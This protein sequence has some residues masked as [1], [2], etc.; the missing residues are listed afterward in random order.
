MT[1]GPPYGS[2]VPSWAT[3]EP[4]YTTFGPPYG[5]NVPS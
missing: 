5:S 4:P 3:F 1:F 2:N